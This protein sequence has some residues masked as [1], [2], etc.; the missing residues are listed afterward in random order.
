MYAL[1]M[2]LFLNAFQNVGIYT[3]FS[4]TR[5][6]LLFGSACVCSFISLSICN[7]I[8]RCRWWWWRQR[9]R[10][11]CWWRCQCKFTGVTTPCLVS[12]YI[13]PYGSSN[14]NRKNRWHIHTK[15]IANAYTTT[16]NMNV[17][18]KSRYFVLFSHVYFMSLLWL[19]SRH[20]EDVIFFKFIAY[21]VPKW[22]NTTIANNACEKNKCKCK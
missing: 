19:P 1:C 8:C 20:Y 7:V 13:R 12:L 9:H 22:Q 21:D 16:K 15:P 6:G 18:C 3:I 4:V 11:Q 10:W 5:W 2:V 14:G 17:K